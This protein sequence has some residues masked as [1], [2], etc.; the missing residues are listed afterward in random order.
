[1]FRGLEPFFEGSL[2]D[3]DLFSLEKRQLPKHLKTTCPYLRRGYQ[4]DGAGLITEVQLDR[5]K[6]II[7]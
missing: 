6:K 2:R 5:R 4:K 1:V 3:E 7:K